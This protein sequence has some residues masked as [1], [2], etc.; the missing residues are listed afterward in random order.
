MGRAA[1]RA[2]GSDALANLET[3][4]NAGYQQP[5]PME[6]SVL[7]RKQKRAEVLGVEPIYDAALL[8]DAKPTPKGIPIFS[9]L[10]LALAFALSFH[11]L[12]LSTRSNLAVALG[13]LCQTGYFPPSKWDGSISTPSNPIDKKWRG[14]AHSKQFD[15]F[16]RLSAGLPEAADAAHAGLGMSREEIQV[17][18]LE[19]RARLPVGCV[20]LFSFISVVITLTFDAFSFL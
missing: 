6:A 16:A 15:R 11:L 5:P 20:F 14:G 4:W 8:L 18:A 10:A 7:E 3:T 13:H 12:S 2:I 17:L 9:L 1:S 19:V